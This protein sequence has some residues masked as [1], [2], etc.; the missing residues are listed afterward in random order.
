MTEPDYRRICFVIMPFGVKPVG[1]R[2]LPFVPLWTR[3][4]A[5][6]DAIYERIYRPA[7]SS[8]ELPEGGQ[9]VPH[10]ADK[11]FFAGTIGEEMFRYL[12]Y[13][14]MVVAD[15]SADNANVFYELGVRHRARE[16]G[17][18]LFR[19]TD[20]SIPFDINQVRAFPY[21][22]QPEKHA[23][24]SRDLIAKVL[25]ESLLQLR[26]DSPVQLALGRQRYEAEREPL[27]EAVLR[28]AEDN[29]R[30]RDK[31]A[32]AH[33]YRIA[34]DRYGAGPLIR[35][36]LAL[37]YRDSARW[38]DALRELQIVTEE[39]PTY[40][41]AHRERG[42]VENKRFEQR[43][44]A[45]NPDL[46]ESGV[47]SLQQ[48]LSLSPG[49]YDALA[50]LGGIYKRLGR[51]EE[52]FAMYRQA[53]EASLGHP[54]PLLNEIKLQA[55]ALGYLP[56]DEHRREQLER[57]ERMRL[58][59]TQD[60]PPSDAPWCFFDLAEIQLYLRR[61]GAFQHVIDKVIQLDVA[62]WQLQTFADSLAP[63]LDLNVLEVTQRA[64]LVD[65]LEKLV[66]RGI[67]PK[68]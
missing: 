17:T 64:D 47:R 51:L 68:R 37:I 19:Q 13:S 58:A 63:M 2:K 29:L 34:L 42:I 9:L 67:K 23:K 46:G 59:Q 10:R 33:N 44:K 49:D 60:S 61:A 24:A 38:D 5:N 25:H 32:A 20:A 56:L 12:E 3:R 50:S 54:Y 21:E 18:A 40:A 16:A 14:R 30:Q 43:R 11:D 7:I 48:A 62:D 22:F 45:G 6:F 55:L 52:A 36:R 65:G 8:V 41:E 39:M 28:R 31:A 66:R 1:N 4:T 27:L 35:L 53:T 57:A 26:V 15:I